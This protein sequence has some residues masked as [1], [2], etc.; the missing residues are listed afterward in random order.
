[1]SEPEVARSSPPEPA[2]ARSGWR[3]ALAVILCMAVAGAALGSLTQVLQWREETDAVGVRV[4][5]LG[6]ERNL[7]TWLLADVGWLMS[8]PGGA[9]ADDEDAASARLQLLVTSWDA[10]RNGGVELDDDLQPTGREVVAWPWITTNAGEVESAL[11]AYA[12]SVGAVI[13]GDATDV[14][15]AEFRADAESLAIALN[16]VTDAASIDDQPNQLFI[17]AVMFMALTL[18][19]LGAGIVWWITHVAR[20]R[21]E[22][23]AQINLAKESEA[24]YAALVGELPMPIWINGCDGIIVGNEALARMLDIDDPAD[25]IGIRPNQYFAP[26]SF[27]PGDRIDH[28]AAS[29]GVTTAHQVSADLPIGRRLLQMYRRVIEFDGEAVDL[30]AVLDITDATD[31]EI[32]LA[33]AEELQR[34]ILDNLGAGLLVHQPV[35]AVLA[36]NRSLEKMFGIVASEKTLVEQV[37]KPG[38][39]LFNVDGT[40]SGPDTWPPLKVLQTGE[41]ERGCVVEA[42]RENEPS[43]WYSIDSC[44]LSVPV[45]GCERPVL[46]AVTDITD[47]IEFE[48]QLAQERELLRATFGSVHAGVLAVRADGL[49]I[50]ANETFRQLTRGAFSAGQNL[51]DRPYPYVIC[52]PNG[53]ELAAEERPLESALRGEPVTDIAVVL[54][55][56]DGTDVELLAS[57]AELRSRDE[58]AGA[59]LT[60]H[61]VS[62]LRAAERDLRRLATVDTL[63]GLPNRRAVVNH[64]DHALAWKTRLPGQMSVLFVDLD[65]FKVINDTLGHEAGDELQA[66]VGERL[67]SVMRSGDVIGRIGGDEFIVVVEQVGPDIA[68]D[69]VKGIEDELSRPFLLEAGV[70]HIGGSIGLVHNEANATAT[71]LLAAADAAMYER[72]RQRKA[73]A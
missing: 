46:T 65:G 30:W 31:G 17:R 8:E 45:G 42:R 44:Q 26:E 36:A 32:A 11:Y 13:A 3:T 48:R 21:V 24:K 50:E 39:Q 14:D 73:D 67:R 2:S 19:G 38:V 1:M 71:D 72:K 34:E 16:D 33:Q 5:V 10:V 7:V 12:D 18:I 43:S 35:G 59:V 9:V 55:R 61:D 49:I 62:E 58:I 51:R 23:E 29:D 69:L 22:R 54:K 70:V 40:P 15:L 4:D 25:L 64:L 60:L 63:T 37:A 6:R 56:A 57:S 27:E 53:M 66:A 52:Y 47:R 41:A 20:K 28:L 68:Q